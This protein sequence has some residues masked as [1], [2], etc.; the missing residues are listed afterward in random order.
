MV[1]KICSLILALLLAV[2]LCACSNNTG[3]IVESQ[4]ASTAA[5]NESITTGKTES[6]ESA[7]TTVS[8]S[9]DTDYTVDTAPGTVTDTNGNAI[10]SGSA[11]VSFSGT[12]KTI[13][14]AYLIDGVNVEITS[15]AYSSESGSSDQVVF[16]VV[17]GGSLTVKGSS[18][19]YVGITKTGSA[20]SGG[21]VND[22]YNF[23]GVNSGIVV[24]GSKSTA[25]IENA[26]ISTSANGSNA[27]VA[28]ADATVTICDSVISTA[29]NSGSRGLHATYGGTINASNVDITTQG[30][31]CAA[32]ATDRG[33][34]T[35]NASD[36]T[37]ET[38]SAG[39][40]L[41]YSTGTIS[42]SNSTGT[43]NAAQM[44]VVEGGSSA[45]ITS[46]DFSCSGGG[47]RTG[48]SES[49]SSSHVIDA[50]GI[51]IYQSFSGDASNGTDYFK[52]TDSTFTV[53][54]SG[55]P[56]FY[57]TNI[58]AK[59]TLDGNT[60]N[61][62]SDSDYL[63]IAEENDQWGKVGK[64]GGKATVSLTNQSVNGYTAFVGTSSSSL[65]FTA[66]DSS[67]TN[68]SKTTGTW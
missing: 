23:Y 1:K 36:M 22:N 58:T 29:G 43:A 61:S 57:I 34:G 63:F 12:S 30:A 38:N 11:T 20:A 2:G 26:S 10:G 64:N 31:S 44:V 45:E 50:G 39:S 59:I 24:A 41:V 65:E 28:T 66:A 51:F 15:G 17:N 6:A 13:N 46:C 40:P 18:S 67:S 35:I 60:F 56:M 48:T 3:T 49:N 52:A 42:V 14:A 4:D 37:L 9:G 16:L 53:T 25:T 33:G 55:V 8:E 47:N 19:S 27:I 32:L 21:Q 54:T 68:I 7:K 5:E 62:A